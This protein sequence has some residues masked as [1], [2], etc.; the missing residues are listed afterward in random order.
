MNTSPPIIPDIIDQHAEEAAFLWFQRDAAIHEPHY[1]LEDLSELD[2]RV[3]AHIDGLRIAG[4]AGWDIARQALSWKEPGETFTAAVLAFESQQS[5]R[6]DTVLELGMSQPE[7]LRGLVSAL[8]W[9]PFNNI[10]QYVE[11]FLKADTAEQHYLGIAAC[12]IHRVNPGQHLERAIADANPQL[13]ARALR[14]TGELGRKD[15]L[16]KIQ[17]QYQADDEATRFWAAWSAVLLGR[18]QKAVEILKAFSLSPSPFQTRALAVLLRT[19]NFKNA[20]DWLITMAEKPE[21]LR[22]LIMGVGIVGDPAHVSWLIQQMKNP[23]MARIAGESFTFITGAAL[24]DEDLE[25]EDEPAGFAAGPTEDPEDEDVTL[26][27]DE[28]LLWPEPTLVQA[29]WDK[30]Q[31]QYFS[32]TRYLVGKPI[33]TEHCQQLLVTG[34]QRQRISAAL[35]LAMMQANAPLFETRA[36]GWRQLK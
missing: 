10:V 25:A 33:S 28:D 30:H 24:D 35:E 15:L 20:N 23:D 26:D 8:G 14:A 4:D 5:E 13:R 3:E 36:P 11:Q 21:L 34:L 7:L 1:D 9:M 32:D 22:F 18:R 29:W 6:I 17:Q 16:P 27:Q 31:G 2:E 19:M 12:A